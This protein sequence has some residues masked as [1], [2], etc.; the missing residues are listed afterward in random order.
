MQGQKSVLKIFR[1]LLGHDGFSIVKDK[2]S[3]HGVLAV[4]LI[5]DYSQCRRKSQA[6]LQRSALF[7]VGINH[8]QS[9]TRLQL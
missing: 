3:D 8:Y 6:F 4:R 9:E 1:T 2:A 7:Q 5:I